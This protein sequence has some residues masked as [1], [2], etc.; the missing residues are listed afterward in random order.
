MENPKIS[1]IMPSLNVKPY[2]K[3]C[4]ESVINQTLNDIE[5]IC[6]DSGSDDGTFE[7]LE[8]YSKKDKRITLI[9]SDEKS[10]GNQVNIGLSLAKGKYISII[11]TDDYIENN[12]LEILYNQSE[13]ETVDIIKGNFYHF[14]DSNPNDPQFDADTNKNFSNYHG[15]TFKIEQQPQFLNGHPSIWAGIYRTKFLK[16][17]D[18]TFL[19]E[20]AGGWVDNPFF[21]E[22]AI[23]AKSIK[24]IDTPFY[25]Y[26]VS[27]PNSSS[28]TFSS[29]TLPMKR[30]L[31]IF[32]VLKEYNYENESV[33]I[34]FYNRLF[35]YIEIILENNEMDV[36]NLTQEEKE[37]IYKVL[38]KVDGKIV[39]RHMIPNFQKIYYKYKSPLFIRI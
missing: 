38:Q 32:N 29:F 34:L 3:E 20:P 37:Y 11:E 2:I 35:R 23:C 14:D 21:Y 13:N 26:R 33:T 31:D 6:I 5:I 17:N 4:I 8:E 18:I 19:E 15:E 12:M 24:Y 16:D 1:V 9:K 27:N 30:V 39:S 22:T 7:V 25:Y 10:Y 36:N 28:N